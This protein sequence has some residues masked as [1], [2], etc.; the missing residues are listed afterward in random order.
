MFKKEIVLLFAFSTTIAGNNFQSEN[1]ARQ[2]NHEMIKAVL[3]DSAEDIKRLVCAGADINYTECD[4][5]PF[6]VALRYQKHNAIQTLLELKARIDERVFQGTIYRFEVRDLWSIIKSS[7]D[8]FGLHKKLVINRISQCAND[9]LALEI[10]KDMVLMGYASI[11]DLWTDVVDPNNMRF[12]GPKTLKFLLEY[13][14]DP[15]CTITT[16]VDSTAS[17]SSSC[18]TSSCNPSMY[19]TPAYTPLS[20]CIDRN[21]WT[22]NVLVL[23]SHGANINFKTTF[24]G[25]DITTLLAFALQGGNSQDAVQFL[26]ANGATL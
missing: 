10:F 26:I 16:N 8:Q 18:C 4:V 23:L 2:L 12:I 21:N 7:P 14:A 5:S 3:A 15:N 17:N 9:D 11:K 6:S 24:N 19:G 1:N 13:G 20:R 22:E 25:K